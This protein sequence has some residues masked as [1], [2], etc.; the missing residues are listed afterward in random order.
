MRRPSLYCPPMRKK[1]YRLEYGRDEEYDDTGLRPVGSDFNY[2]ESGIAHDLLEHVSHD[3]GA[4]SEL[5]A[6]GAS[7]YVRGIGGWFAKERIYHPTWESNISADIAR[8]MELAFYES[9]EFEKVKSSRKTDYDED[10]DMAIDEAYN[11]FRGEAKYSG[12]EQEQL[13]YWRAMK[14]S[15]RHL[16]RR[17]YLG[18]AK[19]YKNF[20]PYQMV[21]LY[22]MVETA[23]KSAI[24]EAECYGEGSIVKL[25]IDFDSFRVYWE[26]EN[27]I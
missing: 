10:I 11:N 9:V 13:Q 17:G 14:P 16:L 6:L 15:I 27:E 12:Y 18:A 8:T 23:A 24:R 1:T 2:F 3:R 19:R 21:E 7:L 5:L 22:D 20:S 25:T 4:N 26:I